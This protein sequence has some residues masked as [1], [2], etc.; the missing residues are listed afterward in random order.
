MCGLRT[1]WS[2]L[3]AVADTPRFWGTAEAGA[4]ATEL[5]FLRLDEPGDSSN[6]E[7]DPLGCTGAGLIKHVHMLRCIQKWCS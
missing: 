5:R 2:R 1:H 7:L 6:A 3:G 4:A